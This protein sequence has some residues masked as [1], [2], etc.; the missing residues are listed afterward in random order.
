MIVTPIKTDRVVAG[1]GT[2]IS[3]LDKFVETMPENSVLAI[4]SKIVS[5]FENRVLPIDSI[6]KEELIKRESEYYL[7]GDFGK[8]GYHFSI[9]NK[10]LTSAGGIDESNSDDNYILWPR[11]PQA[12]A[13]DVRSYLSSRFGL[14]N[15]G[16]VITD[17]TCAPLRRG[18]L[19]SV[20]G[21]SGF[22][23]LRDYVGKPDLFGRPFEVSLS[24]VAL[25]LAASAVLVMGE[26]TEQTPMVMLSDLNFV[27]F[28]DRNPSDEELKYAYIDRNE[29]LFAPFF[30][31]VDWLKGEK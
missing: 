18:T 3:F 12:T 28:Q 2:L 15:V 29:D 24:N 4:T 19:G 5:L 27:E 21:H 31:A 26:G 10:S 25:G 8:Y 16:V 11:D 23:A 7:P 13:N 6:D 17:S 9:V 14:N 30:D 1:Q 20:V 22:L